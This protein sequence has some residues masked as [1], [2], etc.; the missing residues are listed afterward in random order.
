MRRKVEEM[1]N[2]IFIFA[3]LTDGRKERIERSFPTWK[4]NLDLNAFNK[5]IIFDS[6]GDPEYAKYLKETYPMEV[7]SFG[8]KLELAPAFN[9]MFKYLG[10]LDFDYVLFFEDDF[11]I[12]EYINISDLIYVSEYANLD[13]LLLTRQPY[14]PDEI[15]EGGLL[16]FLA[17]RFPLIKKNHMQYTWMEY[18]IFWS[19]NPSLIK[20]RIFDIEYPTEFELCE[21][22][23][24]NKLKDKYPDF[25]SAYYG[26][27]EDDPKVIHYPLT[28]VDNS[29]QL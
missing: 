4:L 13:Q 23:F 12:P 14:Y 16:K 15:N 27:L 20:K 5:T 1:S 17:A 7:V 22:I 21:S 8:S 28:F 26:N 18:S 19:N 3:V 10:K 24:F 9:A 6:S 11:I 2:N 29:S 25:K